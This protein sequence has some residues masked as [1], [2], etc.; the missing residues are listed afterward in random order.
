M[1]EELELSGGFAAAPLPFQGEGWGEGAANGLLK[2]N[3]KRIHTHAAGAAE[4]SGSLSAEVDVGGAGLGEDFAE[5]EARD[6]DGGRAIKCAVSSESEDCR[7]A[8]FSGR[9]ARLVAPARG[10]GD[11]LFAVLHGDVVG[12]SLR[13]GRL[14]LISCTA[15][16]GKDERSGNN[17]CGTNDSED[18]GSVGCHKEDLVMCQDPHLNPLPEGEEADPL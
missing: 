4:S 17:E 12:V 14:C 2:R 16:T 10:D 13:R 9:S 7:D 5:V 18:C 8:G 1:G 11:N 3:L 15:A 6:A